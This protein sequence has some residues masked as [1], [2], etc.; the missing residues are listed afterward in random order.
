MKLKNTEETKRAVTMIREIASTGS[1]EKTAALKD[2][3][4]LNELMFDAVIGDDLPGTEDYNPDFDE[5]M[6]GIIDIYSSTSTNERKEKSLT[7]LSMIN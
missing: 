6:D 4:R 7:F 2:F 5:I 1:W 3:F